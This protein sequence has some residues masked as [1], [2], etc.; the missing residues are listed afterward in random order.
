MDTPRSIWG[1]VITGVVTSDDGGPLSGATIHTFGPHHR[2]VTAATDGRYELSGT[3]EGAYRLLFSEPDHLDEWFDNA[4]TSSS[5][6]LVTVTLA[7]PSTADAESHAR[8]LDPRCRDQRR[9]AAHRRQPGGVRLFTLVFPIRGHRRRR[10]V[11]DP[12]LVRLLR[13]PVLGKRD[14]RRLPRGMARQHD[15]PGGGDASRRRRRRVDGWHRCVARSQPARSQGGSSTPRPAGARRQRLRPRPDRHRQRL[16][17]QRC[18]RH[19]HGSWPAAGHVPGRVHVL[20]QFA[21]SRMV[22]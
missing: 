8:R 16:R 13:R 11:R 21:R 20:D 3:D 9:R 1:A 17:L 22:R 6:T 10:H 19:V 18:R 14:R 7:Q 4:A 15:H 5:A 2:T 12:V